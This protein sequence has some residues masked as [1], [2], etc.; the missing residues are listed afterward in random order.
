MTKK[1]EL[2][3]LEEENTRLKLKMHTKHY[4]HIPR[5]SWPS[6]GR[7]L[8]VMATLGLS[9]ANF[10]LILFTWQLLELK[11]LDVDQ[12]YSFTQL[13][14]LWPIIGEYLL[15]S[16]TIISSIALIKGSFTKLKSFDDEGLIFGL[17]GGLIIS[18]IGGLIV[19]L[20]VGLEK[21]FK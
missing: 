10:F 8:A 21:E 19:G 5:P 17:I 4:I 12:T 11:N 7:F 2:Q 16:L 3:K 20:I 18:L 6:V 9:I 13:L 15:I 14:I 1:S